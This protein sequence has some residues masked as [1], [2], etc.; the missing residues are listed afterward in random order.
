MIM[1]VLILIIVHDGWL[2]DWLIDGHLMIVINDDCEDWLIVIVDYYNNH[3]SWSIEN[4]SWSR[5]NDDW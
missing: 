4:T 3:D 5:M 1:F 2:I